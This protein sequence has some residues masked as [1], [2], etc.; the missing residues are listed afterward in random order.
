MTGNA[1][2]WFLMWKKPRTTIRSII[3][4]NPRYGV[5]Y[6]A[7]AVVLQNMFYFAN[8]YSLASRFGFFTVL[9]AMLLLSP[10]LG[11]AWLYF[12]GWVYF[13]T[14]RWLGGVASALHLRAVIA[15]ANVP[16]ILSVAMWLVLL[17]ARSETIFVIPVTGPSLF[18]VNLIITIL[19]AWSLV[20]LFQSL[21]EIQ[22]FSLGRSLAN[23]LLAGA[24]SFAIVFAVVAAIGWLF[25]YTYKSVVVSSI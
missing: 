24:I 17:M 19:G 8:I 11:M 2:P 25:V 6:L 21:R 5:I 20:L 4:V 13:F 22:G 18:F 16:S 23:I 15:W 10:I 7:A 12:S 3:Q 9:F 14:G 1:N